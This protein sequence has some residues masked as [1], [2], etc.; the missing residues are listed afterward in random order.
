MRTTFVMSFLNGWAGSLLRHSGAGE[1]ERGPGMTLEAL[2]MWISA[3]RGHD[4]GCAYAP[5]R[6]ISA[7]EISKLP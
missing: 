6:A 4:G 7:S 5:I 2:E 3:T 1:P